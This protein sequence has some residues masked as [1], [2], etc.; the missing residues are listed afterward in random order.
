MAKSLD[1]EGPEVR[2]MIEDLVTHTMWP[3]PRRIAVLEDVSSPTARRWTG[4]TAGALGSLTPQAAKEYLATRANGCRPAGRS[5]SQK[6]NAIRAR[7]CCCRRAADGRLRSHRLRRRPSWLRRPAQYRAPRRSRL[8]AGRS[9]QD[10]HAEWRHE[11]MGKEATIGSIAPGKAADLVVLSGDP[12]SQ[13]SP[14]T[15]K[16]SEMV[17]KK[18]SGIGY[19]SAKL[20]DSVA[21]LVGLR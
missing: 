16:T 11:Y 3:S 8:L 7:I 14:R 1:V 18:D 4:R 10:R 12:V 13:D 5:L 20:I 17:F 2:A 15:S 21:G 9:H 6:G 19:D